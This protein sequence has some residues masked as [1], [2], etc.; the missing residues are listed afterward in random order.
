M[1]RRR[2]LHRR[3]GRAFGPQAITRPAGRG[4]YDVIEVDSRGHT[5]RTLKRGVTYGK[6]AQF[7]RGRG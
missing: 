5:L 3:Y 4:L 1:K 6:A 2:A 7:I